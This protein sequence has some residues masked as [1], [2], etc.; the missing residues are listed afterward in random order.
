[1]IDQY[2]AL[3]VSAVVLQATFGNTS[4]EAASIV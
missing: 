4:G 3:Q 2:A 1:M